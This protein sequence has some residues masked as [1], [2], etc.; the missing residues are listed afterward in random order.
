MVIFNSYVSHYQRVLTMIP[1]SS[2]L[3]NAAPPRAIRWNLRPAR[4]ADDLG[5]FS[6][7]KIWLFS[8]SK[9]GVWNRINHGDID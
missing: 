5:W 7:N 4:W 8:L 3:K 6:P 9:M 1:V 2:D